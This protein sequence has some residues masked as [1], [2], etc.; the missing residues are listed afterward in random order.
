MFDLSHLKIAFIAGTLGQGGAERQLFYSLRALIQCGA[1]PRLFCLT[2]GEYWEESLRDLGVAITWI[3]QNESRFIRLA[4]LINELRQDR[5]SI[6]QSQHI[7]TNIYAAAAARA[8]GLR[9]IGASRN[10]SVMEPLSV[11]RMMGRLSLRLPRIIAA[12]SQ[13]AISKAV[14]MGMPA[15]RLRLLRNVVDVDHFIPASRA[16]NGATTIAIIGRLVR[17]KRVDRFLSIIARVAATSRHLSKAVIVG[18]GPMRS[19]L[20]KQAADLGLHNIVQFTGVV[21]DTRAIYRSSD[22]LAMTSD[23][24]GSPNVVLEAMACGLPVVATS[25]GDV[26]EFVREGETGFLA[27]P[28]DEEKL[29]AALLKLLRNPILRKELGCNAREY[30]TAQHSPQKLPQRLQNLY[31]AVL[32]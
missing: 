4:R 19:H 30:V 22:I 1:K 14:S 17:Q 29:V 27:R 26:P 32:A 25:V 5:P 13:A 23:W 31:E 18:D 20:E 10:D 8:L 11:G 2:R 28:E 16:E 15:T 12:N 3:G 6:V 21:K 24:E 7:Y 9:E